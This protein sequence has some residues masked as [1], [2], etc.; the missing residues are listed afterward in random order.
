MKPPKALIAAGCLISLG[1]I[2]YALFVHIPDAHD[3]N[4]THTAV[5]TPSLTHDTSDTLK[6]LPSS[7][8]GTADDTP[9]STRNSKGSD[10]LSGDAGHSTPQ[11]DASI[12]SLTST[13]DSA[14]ETDQRPNPPLDSGHQDASARADAAPQPPPLSRE[15]IQG[16]IKEMVPFVKTCY[17]T[18]TQ[19][20]PEADGRIMLS[21]TIV[22]DEEDVGRVDLE[23]VSDDSSLYDKSMHECVIEQ[24]R[25][26]EFEAPAGAEVKVKYPF[27]FATDK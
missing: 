22:G 20:F 5:N 7:Q 2:T 4:T 15:A 6:A 13:D 11:V 19:E 17:E 23:T 26:L 8:T 25:N 27:V 18:L 21:F 3:V 12:R 16:T 9:L 24:L 10:Q 14:E 1:V